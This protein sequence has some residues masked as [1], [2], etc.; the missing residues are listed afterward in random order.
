MPSKSLAH[1]KQQTDARNM[2]DPSGKNGSL[3]LLLLA[4]RELKEQVHTYEVI[5]NGPGAAL[6]SRRGKLAVGFP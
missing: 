6:F 3:E 2:N 5:D 4:N 1:H